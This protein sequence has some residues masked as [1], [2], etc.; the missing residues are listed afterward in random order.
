MR[1][2]HIL[3]KRP[4]E[5]R[6]ET[7]GDWQTMREHN[8]DYETKISITEMG[9][10]RMEFCLALHELIEWFLCEVN[11]V[12]EKQVDSWD[13]S[14]LESD[15][16]GSENGAPYYEQHHLAIAFENLM[17]KLLHL[18]WERYLITQDEVYQEV[19]RALK[20][21]KHEQSHKT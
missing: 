9:D 6:Y 13:M 12:T 16:P 8:I 1:T 7:I 4:E 10:K 11:G 5:M 14:H 15:D 2:I 3:T 21:G 18:N 20:K 19:R 17:A